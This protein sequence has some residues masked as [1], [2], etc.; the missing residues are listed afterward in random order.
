MSS[1][2]VDSGNSSSV[3]I[4]ACAES[5]GSGTRKAFRIAFFA[6][7]GLVGVEELIVASHAGTDGSAEVSEGVGVTGEAGSGVGAVEASG[8]AG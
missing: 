8:G 7:S 4:T 2:F 5:R 3:S 6:G 1:F